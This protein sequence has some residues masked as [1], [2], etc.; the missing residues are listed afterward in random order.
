MRN[1]AFLGAVVGAALTISTTAHATVF[2]YIGYILPYTVAKTGTYTITAVGAAGG[3]A[4]HHETGAGTGGEGAEVQGNFTLTAGTVLDILVGGQGA[5][6]YY[7]GGGGG[8]SFVVTS[9]GTPLAIAGGGG[10]GYY[11]PSNNADA[12]TSTSGQTA[13]RYSASYGNGGTAGSGGQD[14]YGG[15]GGGLLTDGG[16]YNGYDYGY[17]GSAFIHNGSGG[18][19]AY[20][21]DY[22]GTGGYGGGSG[23]GYYTSGAGGGY[24]GGGGADEYGNGGGGGSYLDPSAVDPVLT[25]DASTGYGAITIAATSISEPASLLML[26]AGIGLLGLV[27]RRKR[28][29]AIQA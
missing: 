18:A 14:D 4:E 22:G 28:S 11:S 8:G 10:G 6:G 1:V 7:G 19:S 2:S 9:T 17:G 16:T 24:S 13:Y 3:S 25:A 12:S 23:G 15:G 5:A 21:N 20:Y 26:T 27:R 29:T